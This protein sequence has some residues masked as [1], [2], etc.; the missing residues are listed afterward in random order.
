[1]VECFQMKS[2]FHLIYTNE[3]KQNEEAKKNLGRLQ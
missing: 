1:M 3:W 2:R